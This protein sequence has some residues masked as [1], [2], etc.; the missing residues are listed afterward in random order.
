MKGLNE[1]AICST[2]LPDVNMAVEAERKEQ[3]SDGIAG[4]VELL[5]PV[6]PLG[7]RPGLVAMLLQQL[8]LLGLHIHLAPH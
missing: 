3:G 1:R 6:E 2:D 8:P 7:L 5:R 4:L